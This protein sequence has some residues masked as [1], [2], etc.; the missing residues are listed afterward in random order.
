MYGPVQDLGGPCWMYADQ[1]SAQMIY[2]AYF[3][4]VCSEYATAESINLRQVIKMSTLSQFI[5]PD[6]C[7]KQSF[8]VILLV[9]I[10][11]HV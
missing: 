10:H 5:I 4:Y 9:K 3:M 1:I 8:V 2:H 7:R 6:K 11:A